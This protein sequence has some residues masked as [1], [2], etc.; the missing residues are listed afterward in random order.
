[1]VESKVEK[2]FMLCKA[3]NE[4]E[5]NASIKQR[6]NDFCLQYK[7]DGERIQTAVD[8]RA[9]GT[10]DVLMYSRGGGVANFQFPELIDIF[11][12]AKGKGKFILDG[13]II[14]S[15]KG[16]E[17]DFTLLQ[18][19]A[20]TQK[21]EKIARLVKEIPVKYCIF[22]VL[23]YN[24]QDTKKLSL[25]ERQIILTKLFADEGLVIPVTENQDTVSSLELVENL[26]L[27]KAMA[28]AKELDKE[29]LI[30]KDLGSTY[31]GGKRVWGKYK[32]WLEGEITV[33]QYETNNAGIRVASADGKLACQIAGFQSNEVKDLL[34]KGLDVT[35]SIQYLETFEDEKG[36]KSYRFPSYRGV[37]EAKK[38]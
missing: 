21:K 1:M 31:E 17:D 37:V 13:E 11:K 29:G 19:R 4:D 15:V 25:R 20:K 30:L 14:T 22:D 12:K 24:G 8:I 3:I 33:S 34:D 26:P 38:K 10:K 18:S 36:V 28:M 6:P 16:K 23:M 7:Y 9:D 32:R 35:I 2:M 5:V 27:D